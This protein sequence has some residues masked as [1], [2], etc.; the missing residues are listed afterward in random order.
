LGLS[1][2][3][4]RRTIPRMP[5][6]LLYDPD[7]IDRPPRVPKRDHKSSLLRVFPQD[8]KFYKVDGRTRS[9][10]LLRNTRDALLEQLNRKP[11]SAE[12]L[13]I[14]RLAWLHL[15]TQFLDRRILDGTVDITEAASYASQINSFSRGLANLGLLGNA[16]N[17][18]TLDAN[19]GPAQTST[20]TPQGSRLT[21]ERD[22]VDAE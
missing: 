17:L 16:L 2:E 22:Q 15:C 21:R 19:Q 7:P 11:T 8:G 4:L 5:R 13:L 10:Q 18:P 6:V 20:H 3:Y 14:E 12:R 1:V 9:G